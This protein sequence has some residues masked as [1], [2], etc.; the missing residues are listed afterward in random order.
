[1][2]LEG[3]KSLSSCNLSEHYLF[4]TPKLSVP[5]PG[6]AGEALGFAGE[7][8]GGRPKGPARDVAEA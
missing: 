1:M 4:A 2:G 8:Q 7:T 3:G 6:N 5:V